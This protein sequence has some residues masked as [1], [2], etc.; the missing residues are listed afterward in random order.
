M[1]E[2]QFKQK[3]HGSGLFRELFCYLLTLVP[4]EICYVEAFANKANVKSQNILAHLKLER[5]GENKTGNL[6]RYVGRYEDMKRVI[7]EE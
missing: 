1:E 3:Y 6:F 4:E 5:V 7:V 2:I